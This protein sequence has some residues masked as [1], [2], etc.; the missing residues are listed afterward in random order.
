MPSEVVDR[1]ADVWEALIAVADAAGGQWP[2]RARAAAVA[3]VVASKEGE[4]SLGVRLLAD[5]RTVFGEQEQATTKAILAA[6]HDLPEAPWHDLRGK[7]LDER[8]L[9]YRLRQY[10]IKSRNI[11]VG[12][13]RPKGYTRAD[14]HDAWARYTPPPPATSAT[15][16]TNATGEEIK[17]PEVADDVADETARSATKN[18]KNGGPVAHVAAVADLRL[19]ECVCQHCGRNG[20]LLTAYSGGDPI[21]LHR[22]CLEP[23]MA[24]E[25]PP[26][27]RRS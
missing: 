20:E 25:I 10:G 2:A 16:A 7:P 14:L 3:L 6:L 21:Q 5:L 15:S 12:D 1:D 26:M 27:L 17:A 24:L 22:E 9:A 13:T 19:G 8:G 23:F 11:A 18:P 4:P